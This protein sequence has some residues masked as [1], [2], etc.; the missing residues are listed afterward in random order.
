MKKF[1]LLIL[2]FGVFSNFVDAQ[3]ENC[4][5][6]INCDPNRE[7][8]YRF[9]DGITRCTANPADEVNPGVVKAPFPVCLSYNPDK[10]PHNVML[11]N[12]PGL[13]E[14]FDDSKVE[15]D[16]HCAE[17]QWNCLC[18]MQNAD[19][20]CMINLVWTQ[21]PKD[22]EDPTSRVAEAATRWAG[23]I[24]KC[25]GTGFPPS[26]IVLNNTTGF[27]YPKN[28]NSRRILVN[29][30][31]EYY[32]VNQ[33][34]DGLANNT[35]NLCDIITHELG[36]I[37]GLKHYN[38][39]PI[40]APIITLANGIM[41]S[42]AKA[43]QAKRELTDDDKCAFSR[44]YCNAVHVENSD[45]LFSKIQVKTYPTPTQ[46]TLNIEFT[47]NGVAVDL[48]FQ[49]FNE[50]GKLVY[51]NGYYFPNQGLNRIT[52]D[53]SFLTNGIYYFKIHSMKNVF[54]GKFVI[55]K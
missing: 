40:C 23:C 12:G 47:I 16:M 36:H 49:V 4:G 13:V 1:I 6:H 31:C 45:S 46:S 24:V 30:D 9:C 32:K 43:N 42:N 27:N 41:N 10:G 8:P 55:A 20:L 18:G 53:F 37:Y 29:S 7:Y 50:T 52:T 35:L 38:E 33:N 51:D 11:S 26:I 22:I 39:K 5:V 14:V 25:N 48:I 19:C 54:S 15:A 34:W 28:T 2:L 3:D 17:F 44:L 21:E